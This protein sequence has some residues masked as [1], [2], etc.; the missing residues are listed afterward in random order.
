MWGWPSIYWRA[1]EWAARSGVEIMATYED[2]SL[3][4][5]E[6]A[7]KPRPGYDQMLAHIGSGQVDLV[8]RPDGPSPEQS[9][10]VG[11]PPAHLQCRLRACTGVM[12]DLLD[13]YV[14][15]TVI[16]WLGDP[17]IYAD[18]SHVNDSRRRAGRG[19]RRSSSAPTS[20]ISS[21]RR[22]P[23]GSTRSS[24]PGSP[25]DRKAKIADAEDRVRAASR[26]GRRSS[27]PTSGRRLR[28]GGRS[29]ACR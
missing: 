19:R 17:R 5:S 24:S 4:A 6:Y 22:S 21:G 2:V 18:V 3:S 13:A 14:E 26:R 25:S 15:E 12:Q 9:P 29:S 10:E 16:A 28:T 23:A 11:R 7:R 27:R 8:Q 20:R 1:D